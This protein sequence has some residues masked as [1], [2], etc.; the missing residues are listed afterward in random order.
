[1]KD[2]GSTEVVVVSS[3]V[4]VVRVL[5][6]EIIGVGTLKEE[7]ESIVVVNDAVLLFVVW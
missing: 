5:L 1:M 4:T 3:K 2:V 7:K 6:E